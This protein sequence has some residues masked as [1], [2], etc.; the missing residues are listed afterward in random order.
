[1]N[2]MLSIS[3]R[4]LERNTIDLNR[5]WIFKLLIFYGLSGFSGLRPVFADTKH[6]PSADRYLS[7]YNPYTKED[8]NIVYW[9]NGEYDL[10][11]RNV[12]GPPPAPLAVFDVHLVAK[13]P[14][15]AQTIVVARS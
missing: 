2:S 10:T 1:M 13:A 3:N 6:T 11:G 14:G 5:R 12:N 7:L 15:Q 4:N 9:S 8:L